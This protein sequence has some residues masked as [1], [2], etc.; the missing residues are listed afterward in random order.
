MKSVDADARYVSILSM[1]RCRFSFIFPWKINDETIVARLRNRPH[2]YDS[3]LS[4]ALIKPV[5][6][7]NRHTHWLFIGNL[8]CKFYTKL[9]LENYRK[10]Q[11]PTHLDKESLSAAFIDSVI[12]IARSQMVLCLFSKTH[13]KFIVPPFSGKKMFHA[14]SKIINALASVSH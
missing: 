1:T 12:M 5:M 3:L 13:S 11:H 2:I 14:V 8:Q 6:T 7:R 4:I 9:Q 10:Q